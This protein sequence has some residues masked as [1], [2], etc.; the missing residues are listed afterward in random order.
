MIS[1]PDTFGDKMVN[2]M[3][4][5]EPQIAAVHRKGTISFNPK[6][7]TLKGNTSDK[8]REVYGGLSDTRLLG[9]ILIHELL[10]A[11]KDFGSDG[12][13]RAKSLE[14]TMKVY[15]ACFKGTE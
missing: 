2:A 4:S 5:T 9:M 1:V 12:D 3:L 13:N 6:G 14:H 8:T 10:H 15:E 7:A 11:T